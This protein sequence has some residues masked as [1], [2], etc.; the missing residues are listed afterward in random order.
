MTLKEIISYVCL[1]FIVTEMVSET[2]APSTSTVSSITETFLSSTEA[3]VETE[4]VTLST[5]ST[6]EISTSEQSS[7]STTQSTTEQLTEEG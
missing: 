4:I 5:A 2:E 7:I 3:T 1:C 6:I